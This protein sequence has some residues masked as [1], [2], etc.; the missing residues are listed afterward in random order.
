MNET[1]ERIV[2]GRRIE[3]ITSILLVVR[4]PW[5]AVITA[6]PHYQQRAHL[7]AAQIPS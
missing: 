7:H 1:I 4:H 2:A 6:M 3:V 5:S